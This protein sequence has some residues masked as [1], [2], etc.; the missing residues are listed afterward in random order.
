MD[1]IVVDRRVRF[2]GS[3]ITENS[4]VRL[5][6]EYAMKRKREE[7]TVVGWISDV[8]G[9]VVLSP[10]LEGFRC[11]NIEHLEI[12]PRTERKAATTS[13]TRATRKTE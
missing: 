7:A 2:M 6:R 9:G 3:H 11:W 13:T 10:A 12:V 4:V 1:K 5:K 8:P